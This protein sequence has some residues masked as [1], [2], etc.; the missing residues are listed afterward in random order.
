MKEWTFDDLGISID[1]FS[2]ADLTLKKYV[3]RVEVETNDINGTIYALSRN[4]A[5]KAITVMEK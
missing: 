2:T 4:G 3:L 1:P 5:V